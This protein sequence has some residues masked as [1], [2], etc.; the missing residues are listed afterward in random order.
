MQFS[1]NSALFLG[2]FIAY[3][4]LMILIGWLASRKVSKGGTAFLTGGGHLPVFCGTG[5]RFLPGE[6]PHKSH[7]LHTDAP[8]AAL[9]LPSGAG[10]YCQISSLRP[11]R[12][13]CPS[14]SAVPR[15]P[16]AERSVESIHTGSPVPLST[17]IQWSSRC[18]GP[19]RKYSIPAARLPSAWIYTTPPPPGP[20]Y[21]PPSVPAVGWRNRR[22]APDTGWSCP[23]A[24]AFPAATPPPPPAAFC[25]LR[26]SRSV[27]YSHNGQSAIDNTEH[28]IGPAA[29]GQGKSCLAGGQPPGVRPGDLRDQLF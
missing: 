4:A 25:P 5:G 18:S 28:H 6:V 14:A 13:A 1:G 19:P 23:A 10:P 17:I 29:G 16:L 27:I 24:P 9:H 21:A 3:I 11:L 22:P 2:S 8:A 26:K 12:K 7:Q 20:C 15:E